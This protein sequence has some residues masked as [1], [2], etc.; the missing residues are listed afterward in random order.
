ME[1]AEG[2][3]AELLAASIVSSEAALQDLSLFNPHATTDFELSYWRVFSGEAGVSFSPEERLL[4]A[5]LVQALEDLVSARRVNKYKNSI[6]W[7][8]EDAHKWFTETTYVNS[9]GRRERGF[10]L[11]TVCE[12]LDL[13]VSVVRKAAMRKAAMRKLKEGA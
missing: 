3:S 8:R 9:M 11:E 10:S 1:L 6:S 7:L 12:A 2:P 13:T 4:L 5:V